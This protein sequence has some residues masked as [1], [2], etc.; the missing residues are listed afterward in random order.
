MN[1]KNLLTAA[2]AV[3][4]IVITTIAFVK[5]FDMKLDQNGDN[6]FYFSLA[7]SLSQGDGY[8]DGI[9]FGKLTPH[10]H[11]PPGYPV[12][13]SLLM[14]TGFDTIKAM[15]IMNGVFLVLSVIV[16][17]FIFLHLTKN[18][19]LSFFVGGL[20][21]LN[22]SLLGWATIMMSEI[23]YLFWTTLS[24]LLFLKAFHFE[25]ITAIKIRHYLCFA[26]AVF[27]MV[28]AYFIKSIGMALFLAMCITLGIEVIRMSIL[29]WKKRTLEKSNFQ[30]NTI[31]LGIFMLMTVSMFYVPYKIWGQR[32]KSLGGDNY[33]GQFMRKSDGTEMTTYKDWE[34]RITKHTQDAIQQWVPYSIFQNKSTNPNLTP[35][36]WFLG[37]LL[38]GVLF[39]GA[40]KANSWLIFLYVGFSIGVQLFYNETYAG[41][42]YMVGVV[43]F[44]I[45]YF[46]YGVYTLVYQGIAFINKKFKPNIILDLAIIAVLAMIFVPAYAD[47]FERRKKLSKF[48][49][50]NV[51][52]SSQGFVEFQEMAE[53][54]SQNISQEK[55]VANRKPE[56]FYMYSNYFRTV[57]LPGMNTSPEDV[58]TFLDTQNVNY[59]LLDHW[60]GRAYSVIY[61]AIQRNPEKF[62][63]IHTIGTNAPNSTPT[64]LVE[65]L[66][67]SN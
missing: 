37:I 6:I 42:R 14:R 33:T 62:R 53:W 1:R 13:M 35:T 7:K 41:M 56:V 30:K 12:L 34:T 46:V 47:S 31:V 59:I 64:L 48:K 67:N 29:Y 61:P 24:I 28:F 3:I 43:P 44:L 4:L 10:S 18:K 27:C 5:I 16:C 39:W 21:G 17:F 2:L 52:N 66:P 60:F 40:Y 25:K 15:K 58:L 45:F 36:S 8:V 32:T 57:G 19:W 49:V 55:V 9:N 50:W 26:G 63:V 65:Y 38:L 20:I 51:Y 23:P 22:A 54:V 11:F